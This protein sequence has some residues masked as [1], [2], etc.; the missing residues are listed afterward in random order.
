MLSMSCSNALPLRVQSI[1][2]DT[3][4]SCPFSQ[5]A[6][7]SSTRASYLASKTAKV[8]RHDFEV[9][10]GKQACHSLPPLSHGSS[11]DI[12]L[13]KPRNGTDCMDFVWPRLQMHFIALWPSLLQIE[14]LQVCN[15][16]SDRTPQVQSA[17][18]CTD[19]MD[20]TSSTFREFA[21]IGKPHSSKNVRKF[22]GS[23]CVRPSFLFMKAAS[24][25]SFVLAK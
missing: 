2:G 24:T 20:C 12:L 13:G 8:P 17:S 21:S 22:L 7:F 15:L 19:F 10:A 5:C 16:H 1:L 9:R 11:L 6:T 25:S 14:H 18:D 4:K 23:R 3:S